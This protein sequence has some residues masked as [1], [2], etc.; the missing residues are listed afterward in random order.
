[1][2]KIQSPVQYYLERTIVQ[3]FTFYCQ[4]SVKVRPWFEQYSNILQY[5]TRLW[6]RGKE[7]FHFTFTARTWW[8]TH[9]ST[10]YSKTA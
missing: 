3:K 1:M 9:L 10:P 8:V 2:M 5:D 7:N 6:Y 4:S